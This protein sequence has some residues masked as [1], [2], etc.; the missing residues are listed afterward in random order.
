MGRKKKGRKRSENAKLLDFFFLLL[1]FLSHLFGWERKKV[2]FLSC[3][4]IKIMLMSLNLL[5]EKYR[6]YI[7]V[8]LC[9]LVCMNS[10][11]AMSCTVCAWKAS[12][13][14]SESKLSDLY[15]SAFHMLRY[16][17]IFIEFTYSVGI[18]RKALQR[19]FW[20]NTCLCPIGLLD[21]VASAVMIMLWF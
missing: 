18:L 15:M 21:L 10:K 16:F 4:K 7:G 2:W 13:C 6:L 8:I 12:W 19:P 20:L 17:V 1:L 5:W 11:F 14:C 9:F 3:F